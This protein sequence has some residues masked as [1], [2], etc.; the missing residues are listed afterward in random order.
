MEA[1]ERNEFI[2]EHYELFE[3]MC[4]SSAAKVLRKYSNV[5][6][7]D[8]I[9]Y[10]MLGVVEA[11][12]R[13]DIH[14]RCWQAYV[15]RYCYLY[16]VAGAKE[17]LGIKRVRSQNAPQTNGFETIYM[18]PEDLMAKLD[19]KQMAENEVLSLETANLIQRYERKW[20]L[21]TLKNPSLERSVYLFLL[22]GMRISQIASALHIQVRRLRK[23]A[24]KLGVMYDRLTRELGIDH[25][26]TKGHWRKILANEH[27]GIGKHFVVRDAKYSLRPC[28]RRITARKSPLRPQDS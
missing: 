21:R 28:G 20:F 12:E 7:E 8:L 22:R 17:M 14:N 27:R 2:R 6:R 5:S 26:Y 13:A 3:K 24:V 18:A 19:R 10:A 15:Y 25:Y 16:A 23:I 4:R 9:G 1:T 11:V